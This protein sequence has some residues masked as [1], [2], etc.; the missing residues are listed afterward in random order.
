MPARA[1]V[2]AALRRRGWIVIAAAM[3]SACASSGRPAP[4]STR[5]EDGF[6]ISERVR[7]GMGVSS[8]F[9]RAVR[10]LEE[11]EYERGIALLEEVTEAAPYVTAAH[12]D[13]GIA[14]GRIDD[15]E[16]AEASL[17]KALELNPRHPVANNEIGIVHR[18]SGRFDAARASYERALE[19]YPD[20]H[21]ARRN[22][23]ILC[24][25]YLSDVRCAAEHY[26]IYSEAVPADEA[27]AMWVAD[28]RNRAGE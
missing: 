23:A 19:N 11:E 13:L 25:L 7:V 28:L 16:R 6:T 10:L 27:A 9:N 4:I 17:E 1:D 14:Y 3:A 15:L 18:R 12:I 20:F 24:D 26:E 22:L 8:D 5:T 2:R 21:Y